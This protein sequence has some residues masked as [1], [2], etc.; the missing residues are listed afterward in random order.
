MTDYLHMTYNSWLVQKPYNSTLLP[1]TFNLYSIG[2][3]EFAYLHYKLRE[4]EREWFLI[5]LKQLSFKEKIKK[6][7]LSF[8][9]THSNW[10][11]RTAS[12]LL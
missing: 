4:R 5:L 6:Y 8:G 9:S 2:V 1:L 12:L 3:I 7:E 10:Y 11:L